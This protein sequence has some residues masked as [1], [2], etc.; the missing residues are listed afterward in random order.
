MATSQMLIEGGFACS[1]INHYRIFYRASVTLLE[2]ALHTINIKR[3]DE[4]P[5]A[6]Q[7]GL[8]LINDHSHCT[9][10]RASVAILDPA[11]HAAVITQ[12]LLISQNLQSVWNPPL[13][14]F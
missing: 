14:G 11:M 7:E 13:S 6:A 3:N 4:F 8:D 9:S 2:T 10:Y 5:G 1:T 12:F